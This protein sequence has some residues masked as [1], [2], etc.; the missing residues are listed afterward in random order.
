M[1]AAALSACTQTLFAADVRAETPATRASSVQSYA[2][3]PPPPSIR[4]AVDVT[5]GDDGAPAQRK[6]AVEL[7]PVALIVSRFSATVELLPREHHA[8]VLTPYYFSTKTVLFNQST[9]DAQGNPVV[10]NHLPQSFKGFG[11]EIGYRYYWG[12]LGPRGPYVGPSIVVAKATATD[13]NGVDT[14]FWT[15]GGAVDAGYQ[16]LVVDDW[17]LGFGFGLQYTTPTTSIPPQQVPAS[18]YA[19]GGL[20]PRLLVALG[21]AF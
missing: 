14:P 21:Y 5:V 16:T 11:A 13:G 1:A 20:R 3:M 18:F 19:N 2:P 7:N 8:L 17:L 9:S 12:R 10:V 6:V 4:D 15:I